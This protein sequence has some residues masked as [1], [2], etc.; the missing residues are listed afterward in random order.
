MLRPPRI[1]RTLAS[2]ALVLV[3]AAEPTF[4]RSEAGSAGE[5]LNPCTRRKA[6]DP[7]KLT[8]PPLP[9]L[10]DPGDAPSRSRI[11]RRRNN[12][13]MHPPETMAY[14]VQFNYDVPM[15]FW[16]GAQSLPRSSAA[17]RTNHG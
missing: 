2:L 6:S 12:Y 7:S 3:C 17:I 13:T 15:Y 4:A 9:S 5:L 16:F 11:G 8:N 1:L 10:D 14:L